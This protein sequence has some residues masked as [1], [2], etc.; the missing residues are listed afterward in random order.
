[1]EPLARVELSSD[2]PAEVIRLLPLVGLEPTGCLGTTPP[3]GSKRGDTSLIA[4]RVAFGADRAHAVEMA[5][6]AKKTDAPAKIAIAFGSASLAEHATADLVTDS[7]VAAVCFI[8]SRILGLASPFLTADANLFDVICAA[9]AVARGPARILVEGELGVG[10][11]SLVK[12]IHAA[13]CGPLGLATGR[14]PAALVRAE[15]AGLEADAIDAE[16]AP[17]LAQAATASRIGN[18]GSTIFFNRIGELSSPA[19]RNLLDLLCGFTATAPAHRGVPGNVRIL[20]AST[21]PSGAMVTAGELLPELHD[22]FDATL[23]I[24]P[25]RARRGDLPLLVRHYLRGLNSA[26]TLNAAALRALSVYPF[27]GN[28]LELINFVTRVAII[29]PKAAPRRSPIG[30]CAIG[31]VGRAEVISQLDRGSLN[32][33]WRSRPP[34]DSR[35]FR[36]RRN[37]SAPIVEPR[38]DQA[39][40]TRPSLLEVPALAVPAALRLTTAPVPRLRIPRGGH[41]RPPA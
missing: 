3:S 6:A 10:K 16:I 25:L 29:P 2:A 13:S 27:P 7:A 20:A 4:M 32:T 34:R 22:L 38:D 12:L 30:A 28:V 14:D 35:Q 19:Q 23:T 24:S 40:P 17:L 31:I 41:H 1:M 33:A 15:C 9:T 18:G 21:R 8:L 39:M 37:I 5:D 11:E 26:L 36:A